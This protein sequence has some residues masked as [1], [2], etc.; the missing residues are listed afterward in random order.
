MGNEYHQIEHTIRLYTAQMPPVLEAIRRDG[1]CTSRASYVQKK[2]EESA[3][4]FLEVYQ[5]FA[6]E[7]AKTVPLP[8][9][10]ELPYW[11]FEDIYNVEASDQDDHVLTLDVPKDQVILFDMFDWTKL[12]RFEYLGETPQEE[13]AF[14]EELRECG[15]R[16]YDVMMSR[17][18]PEWKARILASWE[19]L[20]RHHEALLRGDHT[21]VHSVQAALWKIEKEW[22]V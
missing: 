10:A 16:E 7:A 13:K 14:K 6:K 20:F 18:Y 11:A 19:R 1:F 5:W 12:M 8:D 15:L 22:I 3:G 4:S 21:G 2:Y 9:G 17:F